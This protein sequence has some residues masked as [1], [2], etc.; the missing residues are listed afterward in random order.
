MNQT[1]RCGTDSPRHARKKTLSFNEG[2]TVEV[3]REVSQVIRS[4]TA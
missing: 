4:V 3:T 2:V 1:G